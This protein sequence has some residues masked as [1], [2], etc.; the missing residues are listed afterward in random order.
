MIGFFSHFYLVIYL[1]NAFFFRIGASQLNW[2]LC[3]TKTWIGATEVATLLTFLGI[4][5]E[6]LDFSS[7]T[8]RTP[9]GKPTHIAMVERVTKYITENLPFPIYLQFEGHSQ[10]IIGCRP[11]N[12]GLVILDPN[13][14]NS[15]FSFLPTAATNKAQYQLVLITGVLSQYEREALN[16]TWHHTRV[17]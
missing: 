13:A 9:S 7:P 5:C 15:T 11:G 14:R 8:G 3:G 17:S 12:R 6:I 1:F 2:S 10:T 4:K 16:G